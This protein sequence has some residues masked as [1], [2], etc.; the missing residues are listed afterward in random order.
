MKFFQPCIGP[1]SRHKKGLLAARNRPAVEKLTSCSI[2]LPPTGFLQKYRGKSSLFE[3]RVQDAQDGFNGREGP[4]GTRQG[5][6]GPL[7]Q[8]GKMAYMVRDWAPGPCLPGS[9]V[10]DGR[11]IAGPVADDPEPPSG[12]VSNLTLS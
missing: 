10:Y 4:Q 1:D 3:A 8:I 7:A 9:G 11:Q 5:H 2:K 12:L 6:L